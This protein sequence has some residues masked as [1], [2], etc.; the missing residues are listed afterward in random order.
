MGNMGFFC[1]FFC[2]FLH[3]LPLIVRLDFE[4]SQSMVPA[5]EG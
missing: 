5:K 3:I 2:E 1:E 4:G